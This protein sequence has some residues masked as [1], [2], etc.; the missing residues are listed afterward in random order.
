MRKMF[1]AGIAGAIFIAGASIGI[2]AA[3]AIKIL[4]NGKSLSDYKVINSQPYVQLNKIASLLNADVKFDSSK[5]TYT[6]NSKAIVQPTPQIQYVYV[7]PAPTETTIQTPIPTVTPAPTIAT[8]DLTFPVNTVI[9]QGPMKLTVQSVT[10]TENYRKYSFGEKKRAV[11]LNVSIENTGTDKL[12]WYAYSWKLTTNTKE[13]VD[14][15]IGDGFG[16]IMGGIIKKGVIAFE[17]TSELKD[18]NSISLVLNRP[19]KLLGEFYGDD[20]KKVD[21]VLR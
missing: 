3:P 18:I 17:V 1:V 7:T 2:A 13:Q 5:K 11:L 19:M 8:T 9:D 20:D 16:E 21:F 14:S 4:V 6:V 12:T 10:L 15:S